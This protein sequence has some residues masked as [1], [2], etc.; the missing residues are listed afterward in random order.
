MLM[1]YTTYILTTPQWTNEEVGRSF[2]RFTTSL[3]SLIN[4]GIQ[5]DDVQAFIPDLLYSLHIE[6][7]IHGNATKE[8]A[9]K[10]TR[11]LEENLKNRTIG[12]R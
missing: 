1:S 6:A 8:E 12:L 5:A 4:P 2:R 3:S 10:L 11:I 9:L 7:L